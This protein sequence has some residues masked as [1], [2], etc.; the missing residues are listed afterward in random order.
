MC[1]IINK[2]L[3][4]LSRK[5]HA[6]SRDFLPTHQQQE[7]RM[8]FEDPLCA[9]GC[10]ERHELGAYHYDTSISDITWFVNAEHRQKWR[11]KKT[12]GVDVTKTVVAAPAAHSNYAGYPY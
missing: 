4:F 8:S 12:N 3:R 10:T 2:A 11:E 5:L 1:R 6:A 9:C 7:I